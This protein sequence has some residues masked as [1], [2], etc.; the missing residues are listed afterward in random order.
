LEAAEQACETMLG[1]LTESRWAIGFAC[2]TIC[3]RL[4]LGLKGEGEMIAFLRIVLYWRCMALALMSGMA[5][6]TIAVATVT[7]KLPDP[8][9]WMAVAFF[10]AAG[11]ASWIAGRAASI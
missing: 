9:A 3:A 10:A 8:Q 4:R 6:L 11:G 7:N 1:Y 5:A 2:G